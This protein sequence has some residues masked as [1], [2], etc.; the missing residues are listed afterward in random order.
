MSY[1]KE[2]SED[3]FQEFDFVLEWY[4]VGGKQRRQTRKKAYVRDTFTS[5]LHPFQKKKIKDQLLHFVKYFKDVDSLK[6]EIAHNVYVNLSYAE[7]VRLIG[8]VKSLDI[9]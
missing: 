9:E 6:L 8:L 7:A 2:F 1:N 4:S 3:I 5:R